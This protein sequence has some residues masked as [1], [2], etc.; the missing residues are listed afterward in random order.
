MIKNL[1]YSVSTNFFGMAEVSLL[2]FEFER[3]FNE[4]DDR[5]VGENIVQLNSELIKNSGVLDAASKR[6]KTHFTEALNKSDISLA[7]VWLVKSQ[8]KDTDPNKLPYLPHFDKHR[9]LKVMIYLH[10][11]DKEHGPIHFGDLRSPS[12]IDVRR[13]ALPANYKELGL[14]T[15]KASE[16]KAG[17]EPVI[18]KK[19]DVV[20]F[21]TNAAHCAGIV[22]KGFE[23][24]VIRF[25]FDVR[26]FNPEKSF[27]QRLVSSILSRLR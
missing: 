24:H 11:V 15:I 5:K 8:P 26:G 27:V 17:M 4:I 14:N 16:L 1:E 12:Q 2:A 3:A 10:D 7:K 9:Y 6:F 13:K 23:R 18:G 19:G 21:D 20:F 22:S 25:D